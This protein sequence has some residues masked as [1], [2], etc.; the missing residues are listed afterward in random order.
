MQLVAQNDFRFSR[1]GL[2][3]VCKSVAFDRDRRSVY[4]NAA[5]TAVCADRRISKRLDE[6][7]FHR[8]ARFGHHDFRIGI[9]VEI[10]FVSTCKHFI[11][12]I[13]SAHRV[14]VIL[15]FAFQIDHRTVYERCFRRSVELFRRRAERHVHLLDRNACK[16]AYGTVLRVIIRAVGIISDV[17]RIVVAF[18]RVYLFT[19]FELAGCDCGNF[20]SVAAADEFNIGFNVR[21]GHFTDCHPFSVL[22]LKIDDDLRAE[23]NHLNV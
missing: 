23:P 22:V 8:A 13:C 21:T 18:R 11:G 16:R 7:D 12:V 6:H 1:P 3:V 17:A 2:V 10:R 9:A 4:L 15:E 19:E 14:G 20:P 5:L